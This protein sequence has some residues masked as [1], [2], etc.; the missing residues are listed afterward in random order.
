MTNNSDKSAYLSDGDRSYFAEEVPKSKESFTK[1]DISSDYLS[2]VETKPGEVK[3][4]GNYGQSDRPT[5]SKAKDIVRKDDKEEP[6]AIIVEEQKYGI[7]GI[8]KP[9]RK[10][11]RGKISS[12]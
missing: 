12:D 11:V 1:K 10:V 8:S 2:D 5:E 9:K 3:Q 4:A 7:Y 6:Q